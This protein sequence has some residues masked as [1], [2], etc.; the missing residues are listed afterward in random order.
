LKDFYLAG[1][2]N[3]TTGY[4]EAAAQGLVAGI[5]A[6]QSIQNK[7]P[8][9]LNRDEAYIGVLIDDLTTHGITEPYRMFTSR[10]EHRLLLS[11]NNAEQRLLSKAYKLALITEERYKDY[12]KKEDQYKEFVTNTLKKIKIKKFTNKKNEIINLEEKRSIES[13]LT[14]PDVDENKLIE[15]K[16]K[17]ISLLKRAAI[18]IKYKGYIDKQKREISKNKKQNNKK[19][20]DKIN[21]KSISGLS[22]EIVEKLTQSRPETIGSASQIEGMTPA[23]INLILINIK[24]IETE[25]ANA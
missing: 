3:G 16:E 8:F 7:D 6:T 14:R 24:K 12:L 5:N 18:E 13:L 2:I 19:I 1:Q 20:P 23:A 25:K 9:V 21:Y 22:N 11:Q 15:F 17:E 10:A 4:E